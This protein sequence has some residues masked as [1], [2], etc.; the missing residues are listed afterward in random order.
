MTAAQADG[1]ALRAEEARLIEEAQHPPKPAAGEGEAA[2]EAMAKW[3]ETQECLAGNAAE[4]AHI[5]QKEE[6]QRWWA[7][8]WEAAFGLPEGGWG[9]GG[10]EQLGS[11]ELMAKLSAQ[12][13]YGEIWRDAARYSGDA[14]EI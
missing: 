12:A 13:R 11:V 7:A 1:E 4:S 5:A 2:L 14:A 9:E 8:R 10:P 3:E 6:E